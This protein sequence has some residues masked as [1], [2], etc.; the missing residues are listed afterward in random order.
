VWAGRGCGWRVQGHLG[1]LNLRVFGT[2]T[3][4]VVELHAVE[5]H[6]VRVTPGAVDVDLVDETRREKRHFVVRDQL[7]G[8]EGNKPLI[9]HFYTFII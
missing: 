8:E 7:P 4:L 3:S 5:A 1:G 2:P 6:V 9:P